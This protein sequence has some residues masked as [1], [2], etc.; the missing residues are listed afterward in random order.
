VVVGSDANVVVDMDVCAIDADVIDVIVTRGE[1]LGDEGVVEGMEV[2]AGL[3]VSAG[4]VTDTVTDI[5]VGV[6][7]TMSLVTGRDVVAVT[8]CSDVEV[9]EIVTVFVVR[10]VVVWGVGVGV[11]V[12]DMLVVV[13]NSDELDTV[14]VVVEIDVGVEA[15]VLTAVVV[16]A[17]SV[18]GV[19]LDETVVESNVE[20]LVVASML[21]ASGHV[22]ADVNSVFVLDSVTAVVSGVSEVGSWDKKV[23]DDV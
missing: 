5:V 6:K 8:V 9:D 16:V 12:E 13:R 22:V 19:I 20:T 17:I 23:E 1:V 14:E 4:V 18:V 7:V 10:D 21:E 15:L 11:D 3:V 2:V